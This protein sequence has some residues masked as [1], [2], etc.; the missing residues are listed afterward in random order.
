MRALLVGIGL[1]AAALTF[2][3]TASAQ[4]V[5]DRGDDIWAAND[6]GS[7]PHLLVQAAPLGMDQGLGSPAVA[8]DGDT[9]LFRGTTF[10][11]PYVDHGLTFYGEN[12][13]GSYALQDGAVRRLSAPPVGGSAAWTTGDIVPEPAPGGAY[14][15]EHG[16][17]SDA[18]NIIT[19]GYT[20]FCASELRSS[21]LAA[22]AGGS[23]RFATPC[24]EE[25]EGGPADPSPD[26]ASGS[27]LI[28][29]V[30]CRSEGPGGGLRGELILS[31]PG[32]AGATAIAYGP[33]YPNSETIAGFA[34][35]AD[36]SWSPDGSRV[37]A[38]DYGG[39]AAGGVQEAGIYVFEDLS[40]PSAGRLVV[41]APQGGYG[42][43]ETLSSPRFAG[44]DTIVFVADGSVWSVPASC[45]ECSL[46]DAT[47]LF[48]GGS[49]PSTQAFG[50]AWTAR[51]VAP[52]S[53]YPGQGAEPGG[54]SSSGGG[55]GASPS[56]SSSPAPSGHA[57]GHEARGA[58]AHR[59]TPALILGPV[60]A[61]RLRKLLAKGLPVEARCSR[62]CGLA[63]SLTID[64]KT[65]R[66]L[67]LLG[68]GRSRP[69]VAMRFRDHR[70]V[71]GRTRLELRAGRAARVRVPFTDKARRALRRARGL[72]LR[73][74]AV[75]H[76]AGVAPAGAT[77]IVK[78]RR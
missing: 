39:A 49:D 2:A 4:L 77:R 25:A 71:V 20:K 35:Y 1:L 70:V 3:A 18:W 12:T 51:E 76:A 56:P 48:A 31:G 9:L 47:K 42:T 30:G 34:G 17:C 13:D 32:G 27:L 57:Q 65:A 7:N 63:L 64:A 10:R 46:A 11:T 78:V 68:R 38:Y 50:V 73:L 61:P 75:A 37:V 67:R 43:Y 62:A 8:P 55:P 24:D 36:P 60:H 22:G 19:F 6:D 72:K 54:G 66:R 40:G 59:G 21:S 58:G 15:Y 74:D 41:Q 26:P 14:V 52:A 5:F 53:S 33:E 16:D 23:T 29:Y 28:A 44:P 69:G 45:D